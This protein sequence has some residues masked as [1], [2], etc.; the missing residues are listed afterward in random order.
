MRDWTGCRHQIWF[1]CRG[2]CCFFFKWYL[3]Y[4]SVFLY[5]TWYFGNKWTSLEPFAWNIMYVS[6][7]MVSSRWLPSLFPSCMHMLLFSPHR[8]SL[9]PLRLNVGWPQWLAW[10][11]LECSRVNILGVQSIHPEKVCN[12]CLCL[13]ERCCEDHKSCGDVTDRHSTQ[14]PTRTARHVRKPFW[15]PCLI[16]TSNDFSC[17]QLTAII[18]ETENW[19]LCNSQLSKPCQPTVSPQTHEKNYLLYVTSLGGGCYA[20]V[21]NWNKC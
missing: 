13:L 20:S 8:E 5:L 21:G 14:Q 15:T 10:P 19:C 2:F 6:V 7:V 11:I 4:H 9:T 17:S 3:H 1:L 18:R 12:F 16:E